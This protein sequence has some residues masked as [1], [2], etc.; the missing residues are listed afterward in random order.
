MPG[1]DQQGYEARLL[2][3]LSYIYDHLDGDLSLDA[4]ADVACMSPHHWHRVFRAMTGETLADAIRRLRLLKAADALASGDAPMADIAERFGYPNLA[5]FSRAF[6]AQH[7]KPPGAFR[8]DSQERASTLRRATGDHPMYP[9]IV[10]NLAATRAAGVSHV[11]PYQGLGLAFQK[12]GAIIAARNLSLHVE[13]MIAV[14]HDAPGS[15]PD[16]DLRAHAAVITS[17]GFPPGIEGLD[18]F[19]LAGGKHAIM[20]HHGPYA[21]LGSA[22][23]WLYGKWLPQSGEEPRNA[24]PIELYVNDPRITPAEQLRTDVR[25]PLV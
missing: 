21:T 17:T 3:V 1:A 13:G 22:Y 25:L 2:R 14:Y 5:S 23:E 16:A 9:V 19:D 15:K 11:G 4:V 8:E 12:L 18:Y 20:Q 24:P 6:S 7:G 10:Q